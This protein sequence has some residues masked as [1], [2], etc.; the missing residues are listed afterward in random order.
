M[1][2]RR[3]FLTVAAMSAGAM[4]TGF[5]AAMRRA[6][7]ADGLVFMMPFSISSEFIDMENAFSGGHWAK[8]GIDAKVIGAPGTSVALAQVISGQAQFGM[9]S[10]VDYIR[11]VGTKDAPLIA[12]GT[13]NQ[14]SDFFLVSLK[15]KPI[16]TARDLAGKTVGVLSL[17][18][19]TET[20]VDLM[21]AS[22][23][24]KPGDVKVIPAGNS[25]GE[26]ELIKQGRIDCFVTTFTVVFNLHKANAPVE[27]WNCERYAPAP[28]LVYWTRR[29]LVSDRADYVQRVMR[30]LKASVLEIIDNPIAPILQRISKDFEVPGM[31]DVN[32]LAE[33]ER[34]MVDQL[35][36]ARG[37]EKLL[38]N[39]AADYQAAADSFRQLGIADIKDPATL[40][41][42]KFVDAM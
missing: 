3:K 14:A 17:G 15:D 34:E 42:N 33:L 23:G 26:V 19:S 37:R 36:L 10:G 18:G 21:A 22:A 13:I 8:E 25:P 40:Y 28:G 11:A 7:A 35:W 27:V 20:Y 16:L 38:R 31:N 29:D 39:I 5:P 4:V 6:Q 1:N 30:G 24:L 41:T 12:V 32:A 9:C 2:T